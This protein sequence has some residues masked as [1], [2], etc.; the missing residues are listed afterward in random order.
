M[1][2]YW[3]HHK[4]SYLLIEVYLKTF[5]NFSFYNNYYLF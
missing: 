5:D 2:Y 3:Y 1:N 4:K